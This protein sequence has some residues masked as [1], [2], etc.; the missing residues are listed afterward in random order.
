MLLRGWELLPYAIVDSH[1]GQVAFAREPY[2]SA[3]KLCNGMIS[4]DSV[5]FSEEQR[6]SL[7]QMEQ[8]GILEKIEDPEPIDEEQAYRFHENRYIAMTHWSITGKCNF[9]CRHCYMSA[10]HAKL[11]ELSHETC[12]DI[13]DQMAECGI[14]KVSLTGGEALV[15]KDFFDIVDRLLEKGIHISTIYSN[16]KLV[17][18][19]VLDELEKR[20]IHPEFNMSFDG[21]GQHDWLRGIDGAEKMVVDAFQL[22]KDRGFPTG[23]ELCLHKGNK[24]TLR[25]SINLLASLGCRSLKISRLMAVGEGMGIADKVMTPEEEYETYLEYLPYFY[26]DGQPLSLM[27]SGLFMYA[28]KDKYKIPGCKFAKEFD[29]SKYSVCGHA[30]NVMYISADGRILPCIPIANSPAVE[31]QFTLVT[32]M[33]LRDALVDSRYMEFIDTRLSTYLEHN[34]EC[35]QCEYRF[36][37]AGGCRGNAV[38]DGNPDALAMDKC[39]CVFYKKGYYDRT[40]ELLE[41]IGATEARRPVK[42]QQPGE[43]EK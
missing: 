35:A 8:M 36:Q 9:R 11:G 1:N 18:A 39:M 22:C 23:A 19:E 25:E 41:K 37:C 4:E 32:E 38:S 13:I 21:V 3:L 28:G 20:G 6:K 14:Y 24:H 16:G 15:R 26:E 31:Q 27:L 33:K 5:I 42:T 7:P 29:C 10:P 34:P 30:R 17:T 40:K 43:G 12:M 2:F